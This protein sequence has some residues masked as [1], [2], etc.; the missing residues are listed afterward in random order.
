MAAAV[1]TGRYAREVETGPTG[2]NGISLDPIVPV[3]KDCL[4]G[5]DVHGP[6]KI[7]MQALDSSALLNTSVVSLKNAPRVLVEEQPIAD[8]LGNEVSSRMRYAESTLLA[9]ASLVY[10]FFSAL[11]FSVASMVTL[12][13]EP[14]VTDQVQKHWVHTALA[15]GAIAIS[16]VGTVS[17]RWGVSANA[18]A[19]VAIGIAGAAWVQADLLMRMPKVYR[20]HAEALKA[21]ALVGV[22]HDPTIYQREIA[23]LFEYLDSQFAADEISSAEC[24]EIVKG[25]W[26]LM[27]RNMSMTQD[28]ALRHLGELLG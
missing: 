28:V 26:A 10:N 13:G 21:A 9:T 23:P 12:G 7:A 1:S 16:V 8:M 25:T 20:D 14:A 11:F 27:P 22:Q 15:L 6:I 3:I 24:I 18:A 5:L 17:P 2:V 4:R 19:F